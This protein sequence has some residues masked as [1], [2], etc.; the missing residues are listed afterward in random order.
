M[1]KQ[2]QLTNLL[3][4]LAILRSRAELAYSVGDFDKAEEFVEEA[5]NLAQECQ[6]LQFEVEEIENG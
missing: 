6:I 2:Q 5:H 3:A 4:K 1:N